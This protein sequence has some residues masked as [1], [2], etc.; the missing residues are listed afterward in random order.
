M[1]A[2][3]SPTNVAPTVTATVSD[4]SSGGSNVTAAEYFIDVVG[5]NGT[6]TAM[7]A[8]DAL[9]DSALENV[10]GTLT[11]GQFT[12]LSQGSHTIFVHGRDSSQQLG[13]CRQHHLREGHVRTGAPDVPGD[14]AGLAGEPQRS[15]G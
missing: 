15:E 4:V 6:G 8:S 1:T 13:S 2:T 14:V 7:A 3:P 9:F 12:A 11:G 10:T 5:A